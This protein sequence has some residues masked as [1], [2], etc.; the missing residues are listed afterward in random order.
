MAALNYVDIDFES[1]VIDLQNRLKLQDSWKDIGASGTGE[2]LI[3]LFAYVLTNGL[4]YTERRATE[5]YLQTARLLSSVKNLVA[6][7]GYLSKRKTSSVGIL[8]FSIAVATSKNVYI[9]KYT[10]CA[11]SDGTLFITIEDA[12]IIKGQTSVGVKAIQGQIAQLEVSASGSISQEYLI[13]NTNVENSASITNPTLN[14]YVDNVLWMKVDSFIDS[15]SDSTHYKVINEIDD[16]V[17][18]V[19]GD[20]ITGASPIV[21]STILIKYVRS[22]GLAGNVTNTGLITTLNSVIYDEE[23]VAVTVTV[24]NNVSFLGGD[25][26]EDIEEIRYEAP[27]VFKTGDRAVNRTDYIAILENYP[28]VANVNVWG[29]KEEADLL[30]VDAIL[31]LR[32]MVRISIILQ[33][34]ILPDTAFKSM[35]STYLYDEKAEM[36]DRYEYITPTI[37]DIIAVVELKATTGSS[38]SDAQ[39]NAEAAIND[40]FVLGGTTNLGE[41]IKY[42]NILAAVNDLDDIAYANM[43]LEVRRV[44]TTGYNSSYGFGALLDC[45]PIKPGTVRLFIDDVYLTTDVDNGDGTGHFTLATPYVI[46]GTINYSTG[47]ILL[48]T[49]P[50][51]SIDIFVRYRQGVGEDDQNITPTFNQIGR[52]YDVD[53]TS[54]SV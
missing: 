32:G 2:T 31:A 30:G 19:F 13:N 49:N 15:V 23:G 50:D 16:T 33:N 46:S 1:I 44:L 18:I 25:D 51:P 48:D 14:V 42:S 26:A 29:E 4:Y 7:I 41:I 35:L 47:E 24:T 38:L 54:I 39:I 6:L 10:Q 3:E 8:T 37:L 40:Q 22:D 52:L 34:W 5:S 27:R 11:S 21:G 45:L 28:G 53:V 43:I 36:T 9:P 17:T 12:V 20:D